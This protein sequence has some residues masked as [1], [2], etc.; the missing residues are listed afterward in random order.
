MERRDLDLTELLEYIDPGALSYQ[1]W[2]S[3]GM[4]L[5]EEGYG[6]EVWDDWSRRDGGRYHRGECASKWR[7]FNGASEPVR[8]GTLV[9]LAKA[10]GWKPS[11]NGHE[12]DWNDEIRDD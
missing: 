8:G 9:A 11:L 10:G 7:S 2:L 4:A 5:K 3:V 6:A 12:L 1:E